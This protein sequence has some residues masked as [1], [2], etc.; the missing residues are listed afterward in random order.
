MAIDLFDSQSAED[1]GQEISCFRKFGGIV[2]AEG[3][4]SAATA[5]A[6][7]IAEAKGRLQDNSRTVS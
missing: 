2:R 6:Q 1:M 4:A 3:R 5:A 7:W